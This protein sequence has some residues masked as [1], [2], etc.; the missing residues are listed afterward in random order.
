MQRQQVG[1]ASVERCE[2]HAEAASGGHLG[3][4]RGKPSHIHYKQVLTHVTGIF[5]QRGTG[6]AAAVDIHVCMEGRAGGDA[7]YRIMSGD[8]CASS[9]KNKT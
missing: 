9:S 5:Q 8:I 4:T 6:T 7:R 2:V 1:G 3:S